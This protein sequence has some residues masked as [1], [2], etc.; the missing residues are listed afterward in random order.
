MMPIGII[1]LVIIKLA[2]LFHFE[3]GKF[4]DSFYDPFYGYGLQKLKNLKAA[5]A[6]SQYLKA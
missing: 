5:Q 4:S 2:S 6:I 1:W 3:A